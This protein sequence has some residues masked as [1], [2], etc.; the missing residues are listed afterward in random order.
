MGGTSTDVAL[1]DGGMTL[2]TSLLIEGYPV[3]VPMVDV[4]T[5]GA[6]GGS[7]SSVDSGGAL[8][9]GPASAGAWPGPAAY[10]AGGPATVTDAHVVLG[11][12]RPENFLQG[13]MALDREASG[14][15]LSELGCLIGGVSAAEAA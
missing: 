1:L 12:L 11:N 10:G 6:G 5:V 13:R 8:Q 4:H 7:V 15:V 2:A 14:R 9:V 3:G